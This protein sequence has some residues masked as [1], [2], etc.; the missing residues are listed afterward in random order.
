MERCSEAAVELIA[1]DEVEKR[2][3]KNQVHRKNGGN[4]APNNRGKSKKID[5]I[6]ATM[7]SKIV[8][9]IGHPRC[10]KRR[11]NTRLAY[12]MHE[13]GWSYNQIGEYFKVSGCTVRRRMREAGL[14]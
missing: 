3:K 4:Q 8:K 11:I 7:H 6:D 14:R 12:K 10:R 1:M 5:G 2:V 9:C 13:A